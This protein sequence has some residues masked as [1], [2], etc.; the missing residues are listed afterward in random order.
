M[1]QK[2][3]ILMSLILAAIALSITTS[4]SNDS[5]DYSGPDGAWASIIL[6]CDSPSNFKVDENAAGLM[7]PATGGNYQLTCTNYHH[8]TFCS[9]GKTDFSYLDD[10]GNV[11]ADRTSGDTISTGWATLIA[12]G[13]N[14]SVTLQP[15]DSTGKRHGRTW[16]TVGDAFMML[17]VLQNGK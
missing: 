1:M 17:S 15:N 12:K 4:C 6:S 10:E 7:V 9:L 16:L 11:M 2:K 5:N 14:I 3:C 13:N 8:I